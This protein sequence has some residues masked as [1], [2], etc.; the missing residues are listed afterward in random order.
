MNVM[1]GRLI[2]VSVIIQ[3]HNNSFF[4]LRNIKVNISNKKIGL[5]NLYIASLEHLR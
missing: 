1:K 4:A 3:K 2:S 5:M